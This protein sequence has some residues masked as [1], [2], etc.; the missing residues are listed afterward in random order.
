MD[1]ASW[2]QYALDTCGTVE[3][4]IAID[5]TVRLQDSEGFPSHFFVADAA[6][7]CAVLE[8]LHGRLVVY[9]GESLPI[10]AL[11]NMRYAK[12][13]EAHK[14][15]GARWWWAN[16]DRSA[17][18]FNAAAKRMEA[19][20]PQAKVEAMDYVF[21]SLTTD[22]SL[23]TTIWSIAYDLSA[24]S[25]RFRAAHSPQPLKIPFDQLDFSCDSPALMMPLNTPSTGDGNSLLVAYDS[26]RNLALFRGFIANHRLNVS[27]DESA[28]LMHFLE[29]FHCAP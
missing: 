10:P 24:K 23:P 19:F 18:R 8:Y 21:A 20:D 17:E 5:K 11:T 7:G 4:V 29:S 3:D 12:A 22:V 28:N 2:V 1:S 15:G 9:R 14:R 16:P 6:G 25:I 27:E 26:Q 13:L